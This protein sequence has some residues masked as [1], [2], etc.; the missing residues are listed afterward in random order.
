ME[1]EKKL[2]VEWTLRNLH[3]EVLEG[4]ERKEIRLGDLNFYCDVVED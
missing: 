1:E 4:K 2:W 3:N